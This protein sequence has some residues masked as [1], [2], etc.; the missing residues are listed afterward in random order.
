MSSDHIG[1][2]RPAQVAAKFLPV[3]GFAL[4]VGAPIYAQAQG[5][6]AASREQACPSD[7][8]GITLPPGFCATVFADNIG[9]ARHLV[10][11]PNGV[12]Y[13]NT[14]SGR[15]YGNDK[16]PAGGFLVA[17]QDTKG[18]G[19]ADNI[20]RFGP[21][22]ADGVA[23]GT[24]IA[25]HNGALYAEVNDR[26]VRYAMPAGA[27]APT[28]L[29][30]VIVS[31]LPLTGDHPMHPFAIDG[32]GNLYVDLGSATNS[33][34]VQ[35]RTLNS[36]G[37]DPCTELETRA[38]IWRYDADRTGQ[39]FSAAERFATG[40]RNGEGFAFDSAGGVYVTQ[41]GR[42]QLSENWPKLY[43]PEQGPNLPAE[44]LLR[45]ERGADYGWPAC[46]STAPSR[47]WCWLRNTAAMAARRSGRAC[48][49]RL[50]LRPSR[51][52][53][54]PTI[55]R[56]MTG[57]NSRMP[58]GAVP[59]SRSMARGTG[60]HYPRAATTWCSSR[61]PTA[62]HRGTSSCSPMALPER[63]GNPAKPRIGLRG[64]RSRPTV[65]STSQT[66]PMAAS[67]A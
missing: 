11:A 50:P 49:S 19:R 63:S 57:S 1:S 33:C 7:T 18:D 52:T 42:D 20:V 3:I 34:Q 66:T 9:H 24:G 14:W 29:P 43:R 2:A 30:E 64:L 22:A 31:G 56:S 32:A 23:G 16:P 45:L 51:H 35:N 6:A 55:S 47:S 25:L 67:G 13:V 36:P 59:S 10:V 21:T 54:L 46:I 48:R 17:L 41:H 8:G 5:N 27:V 12:V 65:R 39:R 26:I 44:E 28:A 40:I 53:G 38:G 62:R 15:Y 37:I 60:R 61:S 4:A 58:I